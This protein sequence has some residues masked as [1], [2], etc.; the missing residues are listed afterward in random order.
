M[1][2]SPTTP[3]GYF[4]H[5]PLQ[6][7]TTVPTTAPIP[8]SP[9]LLVENPKHQVSVQS[10]GINTKGTKGL[11]DLPFAELEA[12]YL[13]QLY[14]P[15]ALPHAGRSQ[16]HQSPTRRNTRKRPPNPTLQRS[17][18]L[19]RQHS[20]PI[21]PF[22]LRCRPLHPHRHRSARPQPLLP[23]HPRRLRNRHHRQRNHHRRIHRPRQRL[24]SALA[25][26]TSSAP[27]G[28]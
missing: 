22:P 25:R 21:L 24:S 11:A 12:E 1:A 17:R 4:P 13:R 27:S 23:S 9:F 5:L 6:P 8:L 2:S 10:K 18:H 3:V 7:S 28:E 15:S 16:R 19:Q 26:D 14:F 20:S